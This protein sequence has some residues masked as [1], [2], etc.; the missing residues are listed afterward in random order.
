MLLNALESGMGSPPFPLP[1]GFEYLVRQSRLA[2]LASLLR[3]SGP[4]WVLTRNRIPDLRGAET[5]DVVLGL[6]LLEAI[7]PQAKTVSWI[8]NSFKLSISRDKARTILEAAQ[9][10]GR[11]TAPP[12]YLND[13][14]L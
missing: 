4:F 12:F 13:K 10:I 9:P 7:L 8:R 3:Q 14:P 1:W 5:Q 6:G 11:D 2:N